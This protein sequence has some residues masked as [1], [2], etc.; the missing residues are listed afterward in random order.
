MIVLDAQLLV[1]YYTLK[2][3][4]VIILLVYCCWRRVTTVVCLSC[5]GS[6]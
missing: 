2:G 6:I 5:Y 1:T 3:C 4:L